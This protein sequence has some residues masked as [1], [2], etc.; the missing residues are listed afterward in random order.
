MVFPPA[1]LAFACWVSVAYYLLLST[2]RIQIPF[3][4][5]V[6]K[7]LVAYLHHL[8]LARQQSPPC[9]Q[10]IPKIGL[11]PGRGARDAASLCGITRRCF[12]L[13][14]HFSFKLSHAAI[15]PR[16][17]RKNADALASKNV[18]PYTYFNRP[19]ELAG[20]YDS[21]SITIPFQLGQFFCACGSAQ[22]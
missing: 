12:V 20:R 3:G 10:R 5:C 9:A 21:N 8:N 1:S 15:P 19:H 16:C 11:S 13:L 18:L 2:H 14:Y 17:R 22:I 7:S 6:A 4:Y